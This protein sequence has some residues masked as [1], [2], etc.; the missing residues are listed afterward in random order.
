MSPL[1]KKKHCRKSEPLSKPASSK[2]SDP[3]ETLNYFGRLRGMA[4][5]SNGR[6]VEVIRMVSMV[7]M[8]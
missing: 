6:I 3:N 5:V 1:K 8:A 4:A 2:L 7:T